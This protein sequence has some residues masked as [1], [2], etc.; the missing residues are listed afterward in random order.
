MALNE[1]CEIRKNKMDF[2]G[3]EISEESVRPTAENM[4]AIEQLPE[5][6]NSTQIKS[7]LGTAS[8]CMRSVPEFSTLVEPMRRL[9]KADVKFEWGQEQKT[10]FRKMKRAIVC[11]KPLAIF[12]HF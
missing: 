11:A 2:V 7:I 6:T 5:P 4:K 10:A 9:L 1:K 12:D 8:F 3:Y